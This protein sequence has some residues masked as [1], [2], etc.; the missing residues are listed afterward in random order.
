MVL[1]TIAYG[2][3]R[4]HAVAAMGASKLFEPTA[5]CIE[6]RRGAYLRSYMYD[7]I[8]ALAP[9]LDRAAID[10]A[11]RR[12]TGTAW[13]SPPDLLRQR[14]PIQAHRRRA[15]VNCTTQASSIEATAGS[16]DAF[17]LILT[18]KKEHSNC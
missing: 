6:L 13:A 14:S 17:Q 2:P 11:M 7:F 3:A 10:K 16:L 1:P 5:T 9:N 15:C 12:R 18:N 8:T 4:N